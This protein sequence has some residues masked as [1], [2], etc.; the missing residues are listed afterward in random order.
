M[1]NVLKSLL[2]LCVMA[3]SAK[4]L[5]LEENDSDDSDS[6]FDFMDKT[7]GE[8]GSGKESELD[9]LLADY[10]DISRQERI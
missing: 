9:R 1:Q 4:R 3:S 6:C 2:I 5:R 7:I 10:S 8:M